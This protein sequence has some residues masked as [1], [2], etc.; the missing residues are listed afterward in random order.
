METPRPAGRSARGFFMGCRCRERAEALR[1]A[2]RAAARGEIRDAVRE[3]SLVSRTLREDVRNGE[4]ARAALA[5]L[6]IMRRRNGRVYGSGRRQRFQP[7][8]RRF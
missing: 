5:R 2:A 3:L 1:V 6:A 8:G 4:L 7:D